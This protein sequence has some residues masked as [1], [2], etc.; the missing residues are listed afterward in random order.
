MVRAWAAHHPFR[1][2][3]TCVALAGSADR[4]PAVLAPAP[5]SADQGPGARRVVNH[6]QPAVSNN[7]SVPSSQFPVPSSQFPIT[8]PACFEVDPAD[9][10][11][12]HLKKQPASR[13]PAPRCAQR[14]DPS[15]RRSM[16]K[17]PAL[18][19]LPE[20]GKRVANPRT[21]DFALMAVP[22]VGVPVLRAIRPHQSTAGIAMTRSPVATRRTQCPVVSI[23]A[24]EETE[25]RPEEGAARDDA[26]PLIVNPILARNW[27]F[28]TD[29][30][31][32][33][34]SPARTWPPGYRKDTEQAEKVRKPASMHGTAASSSRLQESGSPHGSRPSTSG[35]TDFM[36]PP[37]PPG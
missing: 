18:D 37:G 1:R 10:T 23:E 34:S 30:F 29:L 35:D 36:T 2:V 8:R 16:A 17:L 5:A 33:G 7:P 12:A 22:N 31:P 20:S 26:I 14:I 32:A 6:Q 9:A 4:L 11:P 3:P 28:S 24:E 27:M 15:W 13:F 25:N 21:V 19:A